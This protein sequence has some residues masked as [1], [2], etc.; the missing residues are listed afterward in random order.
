MRPYFISY[1]RIPWL[2]EVLSLSAALRRRGIRAIVD[3]SDPERMAGQ[4][5]YD[6]LRRIIREDCDGFVLHVT[7][8]MPESACIWNVEV[9]AALDA[10]DHGDYYFLPIFRDIAPSDVGGLQPHGRRI[11]ALGGVVISSPADDHSIGAAHRDAANLVLRAGLRG[12]ARRD[13]SE[14]VILGVQTRRTGTRA[15]DANLLLDWTDDYEQLPAEN[16]AGAPLVEEA[17]SDLS[18]ALSAEAVKALR[19]MGPA[20]LSAGL[21]VGYTFHRATGVRLEVEQREDLWSADGNQATPDIQIATQ[22]LDTG[23]SD[24]LLIIAV[25]RPELIRDADAA[26]GEL[27]LRIGGRIVVQPEAGP[28]RDAIRSDAHAR[29]IVAAVTT[30]LMQARAAWGIRGVTHVFLSCPLGLA[31]LLGY[32][33]NGFGP[34]ALYES[35]Q[36]RGYRRVLILL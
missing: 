27:G 22:Q 3:V 18:R 6:E 32:S 9:P 11:S 20:H 21:A 14:A 33:L 10:F 5:Q 25:S 8:N 23:A 26:A 28:R 36:P 4:G 29:G 24:I 1:R 35:V 16:A 12:R 13:D 31:A 2:S 34:L 17:L 15:T 19:L 7:S 30:A